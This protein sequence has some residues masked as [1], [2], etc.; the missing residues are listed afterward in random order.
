[1]AKKKQETKKLAQEKKTNELKEEI[2]KVEVEDLFENENIKENLLETNDKTNNH[3]EELKPT[4]KV[5]EDFEDNIVLSADDKKANEETEVLTP[6]VSETTLSSAGITADSPKKS[7]KAVII[8][9]LVMAIIAL[10]VFGYIKWYEDNNNNLE[11]AI[12]EPAKDYFDKYMSANAS[13]SAYKVTLEMLQAANKTGESY[14]LKALDKC[15][16]KKTAVTITI[17]YATGEISDTSVKLNC[18]IY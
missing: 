16:A 9:I 18:G 13:A 15:D 7:S 6:E 11:K 5:M 1:M 2:E 4:D 8:F 14:D 10:A 3:K 17:D 12:T